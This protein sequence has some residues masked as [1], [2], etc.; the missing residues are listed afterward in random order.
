MFFLGENF[1]FVFRG[2]LGCRRIE[3]RNFGLVAN[4]KKELRKLVENKKRATTALR[5]RDPIDSLEG[6]RPDRQP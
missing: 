4:G 6:D 2:F 1:W 5:G 3:W